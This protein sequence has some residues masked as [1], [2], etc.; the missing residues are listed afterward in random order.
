MLEQLEGTYINQNDRIDYAYKNVFPLPLVLWTWRGTA[1]LAIMVPPLH[2]HITRSTSIHHLYPRSPSRLA[3]FFISNAKFC[4]RHIFK[5][6]P[7]PWTGRIV[8]GGVGCG[9]GAVFLSLIICYRCCCGGWCFVGNL[10]QV[11]VFRDLP[12]VLWAWSDRNTYTLLKNRLYKGTYLW[13]PH[14]PPLAP[15][16]YHKQL[17]CF[18]GRLTGPLCFQSRYIPFVISRWS[19]GPG[20]IEWYIPCS[21][22]R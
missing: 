21:I 6:N 3:L 19:S 22:I 13:N 12:L 16:R 7:P 8:A 15:V 4:T 9:G 11:Y 10:K 14:S 20:V 1:F 2:L 5:K 18:H 17:L